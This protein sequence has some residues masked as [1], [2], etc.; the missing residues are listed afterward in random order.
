MLW[1]NVMGNVIRKL[2]GEMLWGNVTGKFY[3]EILRGNLMGKF[4]GK[5]MCSKVYFICYRICL[6]VKTAKI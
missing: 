3:G 4:Y 1:G 2:C 6:S 5:M